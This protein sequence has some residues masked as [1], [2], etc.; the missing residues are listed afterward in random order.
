MAS[1]YGLKGTVSLAYPVEGDTLTVSSDGHQHEIAIPSWWARKTG[2]PMFQILLAHEIGHCALSEK[3][4]ALFAC[5]LFPRTYGGRQDLFPK[6]QALGG[7]KILEDVWVNEYRDKFFP[8]F[9]RI[10]HEDFLRRLKVLASGRLGTFPRQLVL[11][12]ALEWAEAERRRWDIPSTSKVICW[13]TSADQTVFKSLRAYLRELP[14]LNTEDP[15]VARGQMEK[16]AQDVCRLLGYDFVPH[17]S[18][19]EGMD[20]WLVE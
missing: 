19:E 10:E 5:T 4:G 11:G 6:M 7:A 13:M 20:V 15:A 12:L 3:L 1:V 18:T 17:L 2:D 9:T 16:F 14:K 8:G